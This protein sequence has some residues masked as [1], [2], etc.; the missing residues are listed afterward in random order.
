MKTFNH[1]LCAGAMGMTLAVASLAGHASSHMDAPLITLDPAANTSDVY[2]FRSESNGISYLTTAL[3]V[4]PFEEPG[5]GPNNY[6]FDDNVLY[7]IH[8]SLGDDVAAGRKTISYQFR[9]HTAYKNQGTILQAFLGE[10]DGNVDSSGF[11]PNQNLRQSYDVVKVDHRKRRRNEEMLGT[12]N[13][14][15]NNQ[16][17]LTPLYNEGQDGE[18]T[19]LGGVTSEDD[20][21]AHTKGAIT[22]LANGCRSFAGQRDDGFYADIH[23]IFD[24]DFTFGGD[25]KPFDSQGGFNVHTIALDIPL[26]ELGDNGNTVGVYATTSRRRISVLSRKPEKKDD[27]MK[28]PW[29]QVGRQ[30]N[31]L[32]NEAL[33]PIADK[34]LYSRTPPT[35]DE[36][37]FKQYALNPEL[38]TALGLPDTNRDDI[39]A[40]FIPDLIKVD[41]TTGPA[42][43]AGDGDFH[44]LS[45]FGGDT[46][47]NGD[48]D[49]VAGGFPN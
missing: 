27:K 10:L 22:N 14:P 34:D 36:D 45:V 49:T 41:I 37:L 39:S 7:E 8:L 30:G 21:D 46:L 38:A 25:N 11:H 28:G 2:V 43:L 16:G 24:L 23:S 47:T 40:I 6:R 17:L 12:G 18:N 5:I 48:G 4:Y 15:P 29:I 31:P 19:A 1:T 13:V 32:F 35:R 26:S 9:F 20:L 44:R 3:A 42:H 33:V